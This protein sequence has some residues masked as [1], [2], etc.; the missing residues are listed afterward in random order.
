[1]AKR[2][3]KKSSAAARR[4][5]RP[6]AAGAAPSRA[7]ADV[8]VAEGQ[9]PAADPGPPPAEPERLP[10]AAL[11]PTALPSAALPSDLPAAPATGMVVPADGVPAPLRA[12]VPSRSFLPTRTDRVTSR[13]ERRRQQEA[14][15][16]PLDDTPA[17][18]ADRVPFI[19]NDMRRIGVV[20][21]VMIACIIA[22]TV[23]FH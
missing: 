6:P 13:A 15:L 21:L 14:Q 2:P 12:P 20:A 10:S 18:P 3:K 9:P 19:A 17:I 22:G 16:A 7:L 8:Q 11:P 5:V 1:M 4:P 23:I